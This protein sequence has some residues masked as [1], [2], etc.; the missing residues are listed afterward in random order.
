MRT[1]SKTSS[2][3][4]TL[5]KVDTFSIFFSKILF[6]TAGGVFISMLAALLFSYTNLSSILYITNKY[7]QIAG[8]NE[9]PFYIIAFSPMLLY[10]AYSFVKDSSS[11]ELA[12][13]FFVAYSFLLG[14]SLSV[15]IFIYTEESIVNVFLSTVIAFLAMGIYAQTTS[16]NL[17]QYGNMAFMMLFGLFAA[18]I[19]N[20][21]FIGSLEFRFFLSIGFI[22]V[23]LFLIAYDIQQIQM[24]YTQGHTDGVTQIHLAFSLYLSF[25]N[26]F[27]E[28][29]RLFG[30]RKSR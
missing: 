26:L 24:A 8:I 28:L 11:Y 25:I 10:F 21:F 30:T 6:Y 17:L 2:S 19:F 20:V 4:K 14:A 16:T 23:F 13:S 9:L 1:L 18:S 29:L 15:I 5:V 7:G 22:C 27:L 3:Y 12:L